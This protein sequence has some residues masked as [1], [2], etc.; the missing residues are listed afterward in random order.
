MQMLTHRQVGTGRELGEWWCLDPSKNV[1]E[2][3]TQSV[4]RQVDQ[5]LDAWYEKWEY[6]INDGEYLS[7][8]VPSTHTLTC[9]SEEGRGAVLDYLGRCCRFWLNSYATQHLRT[10]STGLN[11]IQQ[12]QIRTCVKYASHVLDWPLDLSP[13]EKESLRY[14]PEAGGTMVAYCCLF[15]VASYQT[16]GSILPDFHSDLDKVDAAA[17]LMGMYKSCPDSTSS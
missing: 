9:P 12:N 13:F 7:N 15:I 4:L 6:F 8:R 10:S 14:I 16:F 3:V 17:Q 11:S 1:D 5:L 2:R